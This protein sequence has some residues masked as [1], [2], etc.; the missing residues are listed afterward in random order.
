MTDG[1]RQPQI[2]VPTC[3]ISGSLSLGLALG[4]MRPEVSLRSS[5]SFSP[6]PLPRGDAEEAQD[7]SSCRFSPE[8]GEAHLDT[9]EII[10]SASGSFLGAYLCLHD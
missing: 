7:G 6:F 8:S 1:P 3:T 9:P 5:S 10:K 4:V 2:I